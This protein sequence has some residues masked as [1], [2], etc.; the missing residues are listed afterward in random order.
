M[1]L[2]AEDDGVTHINIYSKAKTKLGQ[3]LSN[4]EYAPITTEDGYFVSIE[5]YWYWLGTNAEGKDR[6]RYLSGANA[7]K[8]GQDY[9][10]LSSVKIDN[11]EDK[12]KKAINVKLKNN[13]TYL[14]ALKQNT[15][16]LLHY[17][18]YGSKCVTPQGNEWVVEYIQ[19]IASKKIDILGE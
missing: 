19:D 1:E 13:P 8:T 11:F 6:L 12:I 18:T 9:Q 14:E 15:L 2:K 4:F 17:Y 5:G 3:F 7:K 10:K 16:P